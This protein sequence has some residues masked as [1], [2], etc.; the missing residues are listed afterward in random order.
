MGMMR[1][2]LLDVI[3]LYTNKQSADLIIDKLI[4]VYGLDFDT[5]I[6]VYEQAIMICSEESV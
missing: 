3:E 2:V 1:E 5:A 6:E 4:G